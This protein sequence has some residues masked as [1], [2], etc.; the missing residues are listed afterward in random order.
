MSEVDPASPNYV[1]QIQG[2]M[3]KLPQSWPEGLRA[4]ARAR[5]SVIDKTEKLKGCRDQGTASL[6]LSEVQG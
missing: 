4:Y 6:A 5:T 3:S 1:F 2:S